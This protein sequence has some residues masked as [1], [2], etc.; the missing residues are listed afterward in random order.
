MRRNTKKKNPFSPLKPNGLIAHRVQEVGPAHF[1]ILCVDGAKFRSTFAFF[2]F[3]GNTLLQPFVVE[4]NDV[5]FQQA[6]SQVR[7]AQ[8]KHGINDLIAAVEMTGNY[9]R[10]VLNAF[11]KHAPFLDTRLVHPHAS[12]HFR[13]PA[14]SGNKT[15]LTD[16]AGIFR[17]ATLGFGLSLSHWPAEYLQLQIRCRHRRDLVD[18][19]AQLFQQIRELLHLVLPGYEALFCD[20]WDTNNPLDLAR[21]ARSAEGFLKAGAEGLAAWAKQQRLLV[22][23]KTFAKIIDWAKKAAPID[24]LAPIHWLRLE[25]L[26]DDRRRKHKEISEAEKQLAILAAKTPYILL[27]AL[28]G[29]NVVS[30]ADL[31]GEMGPID[32]YP[33]PNSITGRAGLFPSRY[34]S[35]QVDHA[36]GPLVK[37]GNRRMRRALVTIGSNLINCNH[38][39]QAV[40]SRLRKNGKK[41]EECCV[42]VAK[43]FSRILYH[44]VLSKQ[45]FHHGCVGN[46]H[47]VLKKLM[48][49]LL[50]QGASGDETR[51]VLCDAL[52][53]I[54][55]R[56][57]QREIAPLEELLENLSNRKRGPVLV[58]DLIG[59]VLT[60]LKLLQSP[61]EGP[62]S[63]S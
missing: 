58:G 22:Q 4:H 32:R 29:I 48:H 37:R 11:R 44:I 59:L 56:F 61:P 27:L 39:F 6:I 30:V 12:N 25:Q 5:A 53:H 26:D 21:H 23:K 43:T 54:D 41:R 19:Q 52:S 3:Y 47:F 63:M 8:N 10:P 42:I 18:K 15:D 28:P 45:L 20:L 2:N 31:A 34:Q 38:H 1:G 14:D 49:F 36:D 62:V 46:D 24:A 35:D 17:A 60:R 55:A 50:E 51:L 40:A 33:N 16:L 57:A 13:Q 7:Q 9:H